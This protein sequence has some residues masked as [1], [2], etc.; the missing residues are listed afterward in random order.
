MAEQRG[1]KTEQATPR[2][3]E[4]AWKKGQFARS[5]EVQTVFVLFGGMLALLFTGREI[6][7]NLGQLLYASLGHLHETPVRLDGMQRFTID[8]LIVAGSC[9]WPVLAAVAIGGLLAAGIQSR[10][11]TAPEALE[12]NWGRLNP[13][14]GFQRL[15]SMRSA[16]PTGIAILKLSVIIS[17]SYNVIA[18]VLQDPIFYSTVDVAR[19]AGFLADSS[20]KII[21]RIGFALVVL[22]A[23]DYAYQL[24]RT[25]QDLMMTKE[26]VKDEV[27][28]QEGDAKTKSRMRSRRRS[29]TQRKMLAEVPMAD[30]I[31]TNPTHLAIALRYDRKSMGA[32]RIVAKGSR[33]NALRIRE[34]AKQHQ[35]PIIEN[36]PVARLM[37][38][39]GRV[40]GE[41]PAQLYV[42]IAEILAYVYRTNAYRYYREQNLPG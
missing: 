36:K 37:F 30:V 41:I 2:K 14:S 6:W 1:E 18:G 29:M 38:K 26:E 31:V 33:L 9:L 16:A 35:I 39:Y 23:I 3:L 25:S 24:W 10:F 5:A 28:N 11:H 42:V 13:L 8:V 15:F 17:L 4:E 12:A 20:F 22:A 7:R 40:G 21:M 19:I 34:I 32:P 27:K